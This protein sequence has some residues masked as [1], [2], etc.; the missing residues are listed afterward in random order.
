MT[1]RP[2]PVLRGRSTFLRAVERTDVPALVPW[3][4]DHATSRFLTTRAPMSIAQEERW[5]EGILEKQGTSAWFFLICRLG[6]DTAIGTI[7]LFE[8]DQT[9]GSAGIGISIGDPTNT[10]QGLGTDALE[11]LLDF[12][13]GRLRLER[14]YLDVYDFNARAIRSYEKAG[15]TREGVARHGAYREGRFV[16]VVAMSILR[17]EWAARRAADPFPGPWPPPEE[18]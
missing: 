15:L 1:H 6:N 11:I 16:D 7:G 9:N 17:D 5:F 8:V 14:M 2:E 13:F 10:G 4:N 12:G 18:A 3:F